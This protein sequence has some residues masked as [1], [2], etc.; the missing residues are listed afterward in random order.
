MQNFDNLSGDWW[1]SSGQFRA[2][3]WINEA[4][5]SFITSKVDF[6]N[7]TVLDVGCG[8]GIASFA[9]SRLG[10]SVVG[11]DTSM[12]SISAAMSQH[13]K[14]SDAKVTFMNCS[15]EDLAQ[16]NNN[17]ALYDVI[18]C[19]DV[20]E[21]VQDPASTITHASRLLK[22]DG[23]LFISTINRTICSYLLGIIA[24]EYVLGLVP[25]G[26]HHFG[27][28][29]TP[30]EIT[31]IA[32][33]L[34]LTIKHIKGINLGLIKPALSDNTRINYICCFVKEFDEKADYLSKA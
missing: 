25:K 30:Y 27:K 5:M 6:K 2:L 20:I 31:K 23:M 10:A 26:T 22:S 29:I 28:F 21:H 18:F 1:K 7:K 13:K 33:S 4:R 34:N 8:G 11:I 24:A 17:C 12:G 3:H 9:A 14:W 32:N 19:L 15:I 16:S